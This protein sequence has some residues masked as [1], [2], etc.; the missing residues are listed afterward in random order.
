MRQVETFFSEYK[1]DGAVNENS[2]L[3]GRSRN[4]NPVL[5]Q[6]G[7]GC[8]HNGTVYAE[9]SAMSTSSL[10][11][12]CYCIKGQ[13]HCVKPQCVLAMPGCQPVFTKHSC[14]PIKYNC[15]HAISTTTS[16]PILQRNKGCLVNGSHYQEGEMLD[17]L[18]KKCETCYCVQG[19]PRCEQV[20]CSVPN[21]AKKHCTP[22]YS[23]LHC[24]PTSY[25]CSQQS[26]EEMPKETRNY[27]SKEDKTVDSASERKSH[28][29]ETE[30]F[31]TASKNSIKRVQASSSKNNNPETSKN[32]QPE[33]NSTSPT[34]TT[35]LTTS[36][37]R[38]ETIY[39]TTTDELT[40]E[41]LTTEDLTT[42]V[43]DGDYSSTM[44]SSE[45]STTDVDST[46]LVPVTTLEPF[47]PTV[48]PS[49]KEKNDVNITAESLK[50]ND[51]SATTTVKSIPPE[52]EAILNSTKN[53]EQSEDY[54]YDYNESSLPPSLPNL[55]IIPF[56]AADAVVA[57]TDTSSGANYP[58]GPGK[59]LL[60]TQQRKPPYYK[61]NHHN[62]FSPPTE[63]EGGFVPKEPPTLDHPLYDGKLEFPYHSVGFNIEITVPPPAD[64]ALPAPAT[65]LE[66]MCMHNGKRYSYGDVVGEPQSCKLC[67]CYYGE[68]VCQEPKCTPPQTGCTRIHDPT[69]GC[70]GRIVCGTNDLDSPTR[71]IDHINTAPPPHAHAHYSSPTTNLPAFTIADIVVSTP[72]PFRDVIRTEP[73]PDLP[74]LIGEII[75]LWDQT[76]LQY[77]TSSLP[78]ITTGSDEA[79]NAIENRNT[80][81]FGSRNGTGNENNEMGTGSSGIGNDANGIGI[82]NNGIVNKDNGIGNNNDEMR[83]KSNGLENNGDNGL[84]D[85][86]NK[87]HIYNDNN[88]NKGNNNNINN[89]NIYQEST[90]NNGDTI[91]GNNKKDNA[92]NNK[93]NVNKNDSSENVSSNKDS[94]YS[95]S[96]KKGEFT[97]NNEDKIDNN[98]LN[99]Q[100]SA[101]IDRIDVGFTSSSE[102]NGEEIYLTPV[103]KSNKTKTQ[104]TVVE[105]ETSKLSSENGDS[106]HLE[107]VPSKVAVQNVEAKEELDSVFFSSVPSKV[108]VQNINSKPPILSEIPRVEV[109]SKIETHVNSTESVSSPGVTAPKTSSTNKPLSSTVKYDGFP[110]ETK[111]VVNSV[112]STP[113]N[114]KTSI[115]SSTTPRNLETTL[116][117]S[118]PYSALFSTDDSDV[119]DDGDDVDSEAELKNEES[120][121]SDNF[122]L[123]SVFKYFFDSGSEAS[124]TSTVK[125]QATETITPPTS[126]SRKPVSLKTPIFPVTTTKPSGTNKTSP[127][128]VSTT[129]H[130]PVRV[131]PIKNTY[132][133][134]RITAKPVKDIINN[135]PKNVSTNSNHSKIDSNAEE[136]QQEVRLTPDDFDKMIESEKLRTEKPIIYINRFHS[137]TNDHKNHNRTRIPGTITRIPSSGIGNRNNGTGYKNNVTGA[138][139][140]GGNKFDKGSNNGTVNKFNNFGTGAAGGNKIDGVRG[141]NNGTVNKFNSYGVGNKVDGV[142]TS[143]NG[144][145]NK[146]NGYAAVNRT[147]GNRNVTGGI[148]KPLNRIAGV[149]SRVPGT[150]SRISSTT[151]KSSTLTDDEIQHISAV[152][153]TTADPSAVTGLLK[154]AGCN[155]Y[156]RMYRVGKIITELSGPCLECMCT[157]VGV[158]CRPLPCS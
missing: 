130:S 81:S 42:S 118:D 56:V 110:T 66:K 116:K 136:S 7:P 25:K 65:N 123:D 77:A 152:Q 1:A 40:T 62:R 49:S 8:V 95:N 33:T 91:H 99:N 59:P 157:E 124:E 39:V 131:S 141:S 34:E 76:T 48:V 68:I 71:V 28:T 127:F 140:S 10:C 125:L 6:N 149:Y 41:N 103:F 24:C 4:G 37:S 20:T 18:A 148:I 156:G 87:G 11:E 50:S 60:P 82:N 55:R 108:G 102:E 36:E 101:A 80:S 32:P 29:A 43:Y 121:Y 145:F 137:V 16:P 113:N 97:N 54:D 146:F 128:K 143:N 2:I 107:R 139:T 15:S 112:T 105:E 96:N 63:T 83:N 3:E 147:P 132:F 74:S 120:D 154:L 12:Y 70:C 142:R 26:Y 13:Q 67:M 30:L 21:G 31:P 129:T 19:V 94:I 22:V 153:P 150:V 155:I 38:T 9:G 133:S 58:H 17:G 104:P 88:N 86:N 5:S 61:V 106:V 98:N 122:S 35:D 117:Q 109:V 144:T 57:K 51:S 27:N 158:Q 138:V 115:L 111:S 126:T 89:S 69:V 135:S 64:Q 119:V 151:A 78:S 14:C 84:G 75:H 45:I 23:D 100:N 85:N 134:S 92:N 52:L 114:N 72:D 93:I 47:L 53:K 79:E 90:G 46:T 44:D 73:A